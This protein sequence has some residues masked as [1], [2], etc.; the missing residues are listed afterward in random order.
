MVIDFDGVG[1]DIPEIIEN[2][3]Y[4]NYC[5]S[6]TVVD[7]DYREIGEWTDEQ[8]LNKSNNKE[9]FKKLFSKDTE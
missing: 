7:V 5:I 9:V 8:P 3:K 4:P 2:Q 6:P 1:D